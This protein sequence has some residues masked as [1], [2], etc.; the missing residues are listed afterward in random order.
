MSPISSHETTF[1]LHFYRRCSSIQ[2]TSKICIFQFPT[3]IVPCSFFAYLVVT[4]QSVQMPKMRSPKRSALNSA[5]AADRAR[6]ANHP[7]TALESLSNSSR[8]NAAPT[9]S[10][11]R[12]VRT[13]HA[14][15]RR[16]TTA[17][18]RA[19]L[20][21]FLSIC[22]P[23]RHLHLCACNACFLRSEVAFSY[24]I[25]YAF[26]RFLEIPCVSVFFSSWFERLCQVSVF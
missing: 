24:K 14:E 5:I 4:Q 3:L 23:A 13:A 26:Y 12:A 25:H 8:I 2:P 10:A 9:D 21:S 7:N 6:A 22:K 19:Q 11:D 17:A 16:A 15:R 18:N 1:E 20:C